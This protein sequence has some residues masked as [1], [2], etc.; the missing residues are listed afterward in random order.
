MVLGKE[1]GIEKA[2]AWLVE[3]GVGEKENLFT[4]YVTGYSHANVTRGEPIPIIH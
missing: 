2:I 1:D 4:A 3:K